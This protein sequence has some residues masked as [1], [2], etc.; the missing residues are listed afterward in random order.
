MFDKCPGL[1]NIRTPILKI[2]KCPKCGDEVEIFS[3]D[4]K[5]KCSNCGFTVYSD[6]QSCIQ[7][8][9]YAEE[10]L[11]DELYKKLKGEGSA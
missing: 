6:L 9:E 11:G 10:C 4:M 5:V 3:T 2:K 8:C 7:W 1:D